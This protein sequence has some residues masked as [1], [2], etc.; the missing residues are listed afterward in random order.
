MNWDSTP[1]LPRRGNEAA[2]AQTRGSS[3][4]LHSPSVSTA[5]PGYPAPG[6][7]L[8]CF[9]WLQPSQ[10]LGL[11]GQG[12]PSQGMQVA[13]GTFLSQTHVITHITTKL[14]TLLMPL[15]YPFPWLSHGG[16]CAQGVMLFSWQWHNGGGSR[17]LQ[18]GITARSAVGSDFIPP[19]LLPFHQL[20]RTGSMRVL[21]IAVTSQQ[22]AALWTYSVFSTLA[23]LA[24]CCCFNPLVLPSHVAKS[25]SKS[26]AGPVKPACLQP[27]L[28]SEAFGAA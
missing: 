12:L 16:L 24:T 1:P 5:L 4:V 8:S 25:S 6:G 27:L 23:R 15:F 21:V 19:C 13:S 9:L 14:D 7:G 26:P 18:F 28:W 11:K 10:S 17:A 2:Q 20:L 3:A 22:D